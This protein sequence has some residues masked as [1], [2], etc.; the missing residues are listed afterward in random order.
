ME[1]W[2]HSVCCM[3]PLGTEQEYFYVS[4]P[5]F[6]GDQTIEVVIMCGRRSGD[7]NKSQGH[8]RVYHFEAGVKHHVWD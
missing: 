6:L 8:D 1:F 5:L 7:G 2:G 4:V 3:F